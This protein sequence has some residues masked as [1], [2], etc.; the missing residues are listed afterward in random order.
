M[1]GMGKGTVHYIAFRPEQIKSAIGNS[2]AFDPANPSIIASRA[3]RG[4]GRGVSIPE[5]TKLAAAM[6]GNIKIAATQADLPES[7]NRFRS[8]VSTGVRGVFIPKTGEIYLVAENLQNLAEA[9]F[10]SMHEGAHRGLRKLFGEELKP[11]LNRIWMGNKNVRTKTAEYQAKYNIDKME[12][13]EEVLEEDGIPDADPAVALI[14][15]RIGFASPADVMSSTS[16][17]NLVT[18]CER[19]VSAKLAL[20]PAGRRADKPTVS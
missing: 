18:I 17:N 16:W 12:A 11:V 6:G 15:G 10:V 20:N 8:E 14:A 13:I 9:A 4:T 2:G 1:D 19:G 3:K 7:A 5:L